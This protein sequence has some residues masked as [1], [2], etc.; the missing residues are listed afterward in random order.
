M[1]EYHRQTDETLVRLYNKGD[2]SAFD[3]LLKR[4]ESKVFTYISYSV[5]NTE[6]AEDLFQETFI[7]AIVTLKQGRY[8]EN[9]KFSAWIMRIAHNLVIDHFRQSVGD[10]VVSRDENPVTDITCDM[11]AVTDDNI[12]TRLISEQTLR[13]VRSLIRLLPDTQREVVIMRF[14]QDM[15]FKEIADVTG[16]S[17]NTALGRMRYALMNLRKL[18]LANDI[19][20]AS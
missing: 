15:S 18:A 20:M 5:H 4:Y 19:Y 3:V 12:E 16:V 9:G 14:Y 6:L 17:I 7:K 1:I 10:N 11:T 8:T 13:E 2:N